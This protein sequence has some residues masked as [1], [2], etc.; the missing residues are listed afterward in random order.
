[1]ALV[2][3]WLLPREQ[4]PHLAMVVQLLSLPGRGVLS[5][6]VALLQ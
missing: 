2:V 3:Q 5:P 4:A 6:M 1:M